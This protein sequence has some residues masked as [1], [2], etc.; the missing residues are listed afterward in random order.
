[1]RRDDQ[2]VRL[3]VRSQAQAVLRN[4]HPL[5]GLVHPVLVGKD[6]DDFI[7]HRHV[8]WHLHLHQPFEPHFHVDRISSSPKRS[9]QML[10][11]LAI[12]L[13]SLLP[14]F[15]HPLLSRCRV[16]GLCCHPHQRVVHA[17]VCANLQRAHT[18]KPTLGPLGVFA[19]RTGGNNGCKMSG[20]GLDPGI[21]DL[22]QGILGV[23]CPAF[24]CQ[25][26]EYANLGV[27]SLVHF[28]VCFHVSNC[29][30]GQLPLGAACTPRCKARTAQINQAK[31]S[32]EEHSKL[33]PC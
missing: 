16:S 14:S 21:N 18:E 27:S 3:S 19:G 17:G 10:E 11:R 26:P 4:L 2:L 15:I 29:M 20:A 1:M 33:A 9:E 12:G 24:C 7:H 6:A 25:G 32:D 22:V 23:S 13:K 31:P 8:G 5:S 30:S 28:L